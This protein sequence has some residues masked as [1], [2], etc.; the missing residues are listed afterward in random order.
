MATVSPEHQTLPPGE[1]GTLVSEAPAEHSVF[2]PFDSTTYASQLLWFAITF[3][4]F[5]YLMAKV[6]LPR[7]AGILEDRRDRIASDLDLAENLKRDSEAALESYEKALADA[8][9]RANTI[10]ERARDSARQAAAAKRSAIETSLAEKL[11]AAEK[12]IGEIKA[13]ALADVGEIAV[14][15]TGAL[16]TSLVDVEVGKREVA[17]AVSSVMSGKER[18]HA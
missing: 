12:R 8:R 10:A 6:A 3:A 15:A 5:Y 13:K 16:I 2:P 1:G 9:A 11:E 4:L 7:I 18:R 14:E 17:D